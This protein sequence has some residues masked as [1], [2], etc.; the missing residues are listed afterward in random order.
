MKKFIV[1]ILACF[2]FNQKKR[3]N[4]RNKYLSTCK[5]ICDFCI[6]DTHVS[7]IVKAVCIQDNMINKKESINTFCSGS[8]HAQMSFIDDENSINFG[9]GSQDLYYQWKLYEK[10]NSFFPNLKNIIIFYDIFSPGNDMQKGPFY[11]RTALYN[12]LF[13]IP[14]KDKN[15]ALES[16]TIDFERKIQKEYLP[17]V[18]ELSQGIDHSYPVLYTP[19]PKYTKDQLKDFANGQIK[20]NKKDNYMHKYLKNILN[21]A[22]KLNHD[23]FIIV[24]PYQEN[25]RKLFP[26]KEIMFKELNYIAKIY[27]VKVLNLWDDPDFIDEDFR[28][29]D[30]LNRQGAVKLTNKI[31]KF[32]KMK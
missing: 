15:L 12:L 21:L 2:I 13:N 20:L 29:I 30:H 18:K 17:I 6:I 8:S 22:K 4:F 7:D 16:G 3:R 19:S 26:K 9:N 10:Y 23:V 31:K 24:A 27:S 11:L 28:N 32:R 25:F 14:Y 1:R 5:E